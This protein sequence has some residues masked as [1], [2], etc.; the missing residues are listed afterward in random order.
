MPGDGRNPNPPDKP[1]VRVVDSLDQLTHIYN[2][3]K[4]LHPDWEIELILVAYP[5]E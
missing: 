5:K 3:T 2:K 1:G 4:E